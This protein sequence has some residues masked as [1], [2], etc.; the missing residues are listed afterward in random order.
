MSHAAF[1]FDMTPEAMMKPVADMQEMMTGMAGAMPGSRMMSPLMTHP[2]AAAA[3]AAALSM[4][5]AGQWRGLILGS[6]Q[7]A[8]DASRRLGLPVAPFDLEASFRAWDSQWTA[9]LGRG[10]AE[11]VADTTGKAVKATRDVVVE[12]GDEAV[13]SSAIVAGMARKAEKAARDVAQATSEAAERTVKAAVRAAEPVP[14]KSIAKTPAPAAETPAKAPAAVA[15]ASETAMA[16]IAPKAMDRPETPD[17]LKLI[18]GIGPK[19]EEVL[20]KLG[21]WSFAQI[22]AW[23][24]SEI[25]WIEDY[26][27]FKG[28]IGRDDWI[29]QAAKFAKK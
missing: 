10:M 22:A 11:E 2:T 29:G 5:A 1:P 26:L 9:D 28:R 13:K 6:M 24:E 15:Q 23:S 3:A 12:A 16:M 17:D 25:A 19:L 8:M 4:G 14:A 20:N 27:Q 18:A 7:G 21:I